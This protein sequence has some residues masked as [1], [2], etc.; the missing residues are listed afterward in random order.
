[1]PIQV[2]FRLEYGHD[3]IQTVHL[4]P[5]DTKDSIIEPSAIYYFSDLRFQLFVPLSKFRHERP[6]K[7]NTLREQ[8]LYREFLVR[9]QRERVEELKGS[10]V[11]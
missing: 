5:L 8:S 11:R 7:L 10:V 9:C 6:R 3:R 2:L 1:M 4:A